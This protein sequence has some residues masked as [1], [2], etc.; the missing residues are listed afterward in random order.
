MPFQ[1]K[2]AFFQCYRNQLTFQVS[3]FYDIFINNISDDLRYSF[4]ESAVFT[5][6]LENNRKKGKRQGQFLHACREREAVENG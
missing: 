2:K 3:L 6:R 4:G 1:S 5:Q